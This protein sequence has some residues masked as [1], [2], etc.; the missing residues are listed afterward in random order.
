[1]TMHTGNTVMAL[2]R[3]LA[4]E[5]EGEDVIEYALLTTFIGFTGAVGWSA[6]QAGLGAAYNSWVNAVW[7]LWEPANPVGAP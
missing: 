5:S 7:N 6:M 1:M 2:I 4:I 3:R